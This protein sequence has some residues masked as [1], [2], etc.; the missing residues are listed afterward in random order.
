MKKTTHTKQEYTHVKNLKR[1]LMTYCCRFRLSNKREDRASVLLSS[2]SRADVLCGQLPS[3][4]I[5]MDRSYPQY[6]YRR[7]ENHTAARAVPLNLHCQ[8][9]CSLLG[10]K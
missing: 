2:L 4:L 1:Q 6:C 5:H 3:C 9:H 7:A 10:S 8:H